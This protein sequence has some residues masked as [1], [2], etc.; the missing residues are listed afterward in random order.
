MHS[1]VWL[2]PQTTLPCQPVDLDVPVEVHKVDDHEGTDW[3]NRVTARLC[4]GLCFQPLHPDTGLFVARGACHCSSRGAQIYFEVWD[5]AAMKSLSL[6][7]GRRWR[8]QPHCNSNV[9]ACRRR[10]DA[11]RGHGK[12]N[13]WGDDIRKRFPSSELRWLDSGYMFLEHRERAIALQ[14]QSPWAAR[15]CF[16]L[17]I[18]T[19]PFSLRAESAVS[20]QFEMCTARACQRW[21]RVALAT[22]ADVVLR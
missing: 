11:L 3:D 16:S 14:I 4:F 2:P 19:L 1:M 22:S 10:R 18:E 20:L 17:G 7:S 21:K 13:Y 9:C 5:V 6:L 8:T 15:L 12:L